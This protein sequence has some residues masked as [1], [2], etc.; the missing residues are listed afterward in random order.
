MVNLNVDLNKLLSKHLVPIVCAVLVGC[1]VYHLHNDVIFCVGSVCL[2]FLTISLL[3][4]IYNA[5]SNKFDR[6]KK[7]SAHRQKVHTKLLQIANGTK[8]FFRSLSK[9]NLEAAELLYR[10][11]RMAIDDNY[12]ER[13]IAFGEEPGWKA[14]F[15]LDH[16]S[17][18]YYIWC[19]NES[20]AANGGTRHIVFDPL[21]YV[22][23]DNYIN[24]GIKDFPCDFKVDNYEE[25]YLRNFPQAFCS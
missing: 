21:F 16:F 2:T 7:K 13:Y 17:N 25:Y 19:D 11:P 9:S 12:N 5:V 3:R 10:H 24:S 8:I 4:C 6:Y 22:I 18:G 14:V 20:S 15:S 1:A 23:L